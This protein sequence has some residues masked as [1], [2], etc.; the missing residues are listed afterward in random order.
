[1][2]GR[3]TYERR[4]IRSIGAYTSTLGSRRAR[5]EVSEMKHRAAK[6]RI[7]VAE[8]I[9]WVVIGYYLLT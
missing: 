4:L 5:P 8:I 7:D 2:V 1:M 3:C 6:V 9:K